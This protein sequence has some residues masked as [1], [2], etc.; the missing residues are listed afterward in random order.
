MRYIFALIAFLMVSVLSNAQETLTPDQQKGK[1]YL[2]IAE[3][4]EKQKNY[5]KMFKYEMK[6]AKLGYPE[7]CR[8]LANSYFGGNGTQT[9][10]NK[11]IYWYEKAIELGCPPTMNRAGIAYYKTG[12]FQKANIY[13]KKALEQGE[14]WGGWNL[15]TNY[16]DGEGVQQDKKEAA[17]LFAAA[18]ECPI[19]TD[20][21]CKEMV[22]S[23]NNKYFHKWK[24]GRYELSDFVWDYPDA[25]YAYDYAIM[26]TNPQHERPFENYFQLKTPKGV[27]LVQQYAE[28]GNKWAQYRIAELQWSGQM[29]DCIPQDRASAIAFWDKNNSEKEARKN[30]V[31]ASL[32]GHYTKDI[33]QK[34]FDEDKTN[35]LSRL[36]R[37]KDILRKGVEN[38]SRAAAEVLDKETRKDNSGRSM[39]DQLLI[40]K[41]KDKTGYDKYAEDVKLINRLYQDIVAFSK[42]GKEERFINIYEFEDKYLMENFP[43]AFVALYSQYPKYDKLGILPKARIVDDYIQVNEALYCVIEEPDAISGERGLFGIRKWWDQKKIDYWFNLM[44]NAKSACQKYASGTTMNSFFKKALPK[45]NKKLNNGYDAVERKRKKFNA[46]VAQNSSSYSSSS[47]SGS[48]SYQAEVN[49]KPIPA[50]NINKSFDTSDWNLPGARHE[51]INAWSVSFKNEGPKVSGTVYHCKNE[52]PYMDWYTYEISGPMYKTLKDA[53]G[54]LYIKKKFGSSRTVGEGYNRR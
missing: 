30:L 5:K 46:E 50:Y 4:A 1:K 33:P 27:K 41:N 11:A 25:R 16:F 8:W 53:I 17:R 3:Q 12:N 47:S 13:F 28:K 32:E 49:N 20:Q 6:A 21:V 18:V 36:Y 9:D 2:E 14:A 7:G 35:E 19:N 54:A 31:I 48:D 24:G 38:G 45:L 23:E 29:P 51:I 34:W 44:L 37:Q 10:Y 22:N 39:S 15:A 43:A 52:E 26:K 40:L 42:T